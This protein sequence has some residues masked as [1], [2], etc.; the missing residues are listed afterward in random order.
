MVDIAF[1]ELFLQH[2]LPN[3]ELLCNFMGIHQLS[4]NNRQTPGFINVLRKQPKTL[5]G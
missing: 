4:L 5:A 1:S 3:V 2:S